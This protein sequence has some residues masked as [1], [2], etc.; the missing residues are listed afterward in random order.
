MWCIPSVEIESL[1]SQLLITALHEDSAQVDFK[2]NADF[3]FIFYFS[4]VRIGDGWQLIHLCAHIYFR[5]LFIFY[6]F[7]FFMS[8]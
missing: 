4:G 8:E 6:N 1:S 5:N 2:T 3:Y 7:I